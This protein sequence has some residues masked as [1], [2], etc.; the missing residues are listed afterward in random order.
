LK[1]YNQGNREAD[2][3]RKAPNQ[4]RKNALLYWVNI[5]KGQYGRKY[6]E[7]SKKFPFVRNEN[8]L[9]QKILNNFNVFSVDIE[10]M[11]KKQLFHPV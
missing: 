2:P 1:Q 3:L 9:K 6:T 8:A 10:C 4:H 5:P 11:W 7:F